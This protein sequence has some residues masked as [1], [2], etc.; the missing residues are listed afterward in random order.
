MHKADNMILWM[1]ECAHIV[2]TVYVYYNV[3]CI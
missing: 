1:W 2:D 3:S